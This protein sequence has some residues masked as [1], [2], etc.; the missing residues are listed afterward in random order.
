MSSPCPSRFNSG[1]PRYPLYRRLGG[2][3]GRSGQV[4]KI[5]PSQG[6]ALRTV[7]SVAS[8]YTK[9]LEIL[10]KLSPQTKRLTHRDMS[11]SVFDRTVLPEDVRQTIHC[12]CRRK[13]PMANQFCVPITVLVCSFTPD[14]VSAFIRP[15]ATPDSSPRTFPQISD[16]RLGW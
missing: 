2:S 12:L 15:H 16:Q 6:F 14:L 3:Q 5:S 1:K 13:F 10:F 7:Q 9:V 11:D 4:R 8:R